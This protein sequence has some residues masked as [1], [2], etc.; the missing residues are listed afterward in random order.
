MTRDDLVRRQEQITSNVVVT[1]TGCWLWQGYVNVRTGYGQVTVKP[2]PRR[3]VTAHVAAYEAFVGPVP[4]GLELDHTCRVL[5]C[6]APAHLEAVTHAENVRRYR[7]Q[8][9]TCQA[10]L[11]PLSCQVPN[12]P[13]KT[14]CGACRRK[15]DRERDKRRRDRKRA[16]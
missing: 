13:G 16:P 4:K 14:T 8:V 10:G 6:C 15:R 2:D 12:G 9:T 5:R 11:H 1:D 3:V 7:A